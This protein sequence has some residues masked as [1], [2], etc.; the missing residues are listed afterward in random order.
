MK[1]KRAKPRR[2]VHPVQPAH[3]LLI[4][5][6]SNVGA[7][8]AKMMHFGEHRVGFDLRRY[9]RGH[10]C[11]VQHDNCR[12]SPDYT[13][14]AHLRLGATAGIGQKPDDVLALPVCDIAHHMIDGRAKVNDAN[15]WK[16]VLC[17]YLRWLNHLLNEGYLRR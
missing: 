7:T 8:F 1:A 3:S 4:Y 10:I 12:L 6:P 17:G 14:L 15:F 16:E 5:G 9:A 2:T 11:Y 13:V